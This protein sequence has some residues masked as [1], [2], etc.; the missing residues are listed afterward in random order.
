MRM[1]AIETT[2][3]YCS[4]AL[5]GNA[6]PGSPGE[7]TEQCGT[8]RMN[9][10]QTLAPMI[11]QLLNEADRSVSALDYIAVSAGPGSFTG[12]RIG[13]STG[14]A[15]SQVTGIP[16]IAVPTL[17]AFGYGKGYGALENTTIC[18]LFDARLQQ[19]YAGAYRGLETRIGGGPF[20]LEEF[21]QQLSDR[22][23]DHILFVGD[24]LIPYGKQVREWI[25]QTGTSAELEEVTQ[26]AAYVARTAMAMLEQ[27]E[28]F[29]DCLDL[30]YGELEP[31]YMRIPEAERKLKE[32][33]L[34][35]A[36]R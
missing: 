10:L 2:G 11:Q 14:R 9:H 19:V 1:L 22:H 28:R 3:P 34:K 21:L 33:T 15:L 6:E 7:I 31:M 32:G 26:R 16:L 36:Q 35:C 30:S 20:L 24:G 29:G 13:V 17:L 27:P 25:R 23:E 18:P 5:T 4:V 8:Q 12:I